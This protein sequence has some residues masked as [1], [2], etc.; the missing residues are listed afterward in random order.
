MAHFPGQ[1]FIS[2]MSV[3][4]G[5]I[6]K[7]LK[8]PA[9]NSDFNLADCFTVVNHHLTY[10]HIRVLIDVLH[11]SLYLSD[12]RFLCI[13]TVFILCHQSNYNAMTISGVAFSQVIMV[14]IYITV[15]IIIS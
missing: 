13:Y 6:S 1:K 11:L 7:N 15:A 9:I 14:I 10:I 12:N 8:F 5:A 2:E 3:K 4:A